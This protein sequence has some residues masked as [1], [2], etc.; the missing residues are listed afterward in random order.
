MAD[1][2]VTAP[3][4][5]GSVGGQRWT[6]SMGVNFDE[7]VE[8]LSLPMQGGDGGG[9]MDALLTPRV[10]LIVTLGSDLGSGRAWMVDGFVHDVVHRL[11]VTTAAGT[12]SVRLRRVPARI[13]RRWPLLAHVRGF[14]RFLALE[15][16]PT[17][18]V[19]L[20]VHHRVLQRVSF[21][22]PH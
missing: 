20:D 10:P 21:S 17:E 6:L 1:G 2:P 22:P 3:I 19:A 12:T 8:E 15:H 14:I 13:V 5:H 9:L 7:V 16:P 18:V 4:A 11:R